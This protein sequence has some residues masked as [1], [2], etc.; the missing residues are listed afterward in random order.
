MH[1]EQKR[2]TKRARVRKKNEE[3]KYQPRTFTTD[4]ITTNKKITN[5]L[6]QVK[7]LELEE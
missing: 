7:R 1:N 2:Q 3:T 6:K 5:E 4:K